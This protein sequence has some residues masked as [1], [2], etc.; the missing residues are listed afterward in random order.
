MTLDQSVFRLRMNYRKN[1][2]ITIKHEIF[3]YIRYTYA[4]VYAARE[5]VLPEYK[6]IHYS[7]QSRD[8]IADNEKRERERERTHK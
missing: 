5:T 4:I 8:K 3:V 7:K 1:L 2:P 6:E